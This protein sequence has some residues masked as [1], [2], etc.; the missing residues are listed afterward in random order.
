MQHQAW[1]VL[2][3]LMAAGKEM[4]DEKEKR[5]GDQKAVQAEQNA[6]P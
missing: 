5:K 3:D 1:I 6:K 4:A 2:K